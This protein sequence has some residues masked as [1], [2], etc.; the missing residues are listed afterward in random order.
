[1]KP[2]RATQQLE[3]PFFSGCGMCDFI[4]G[5]TLAA[6]AGRLKGRRSQQERPLT[7]GLRP[8]MQN[9]PMEWHGLFQRQVY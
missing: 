7:C 3:C 4:C 5:E 9:I 6:Q 8:L 1:M 2:L